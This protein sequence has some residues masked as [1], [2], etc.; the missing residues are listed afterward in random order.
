MSSFLGIG[1][2]AAISK[3]IIWMPCHLAGRTG[4]SILG[5]PNGPNDEMVSISRHIVEIESCRKMKQS[6]CHAA[7]SV[8]A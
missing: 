2:K 5:Y 6:P 8:C 7:V 1:K 3:L 4:S